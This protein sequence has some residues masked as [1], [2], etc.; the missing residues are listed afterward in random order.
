MS[1]SIT[2]NYSALNVLTEAQLDAAFDSIENKFN[3]TLIAGTEIQSLTIEAGNLAANS[4]TTAKILDSNVTTAKIADGA[5]TGVKRLY[6]VN[7]TAKTT[8]YTATTSDEILLVTATGGAFTITLYAASGNAGRR[9][10][11][12]RTDTTFANAVTIDANLSE[13]IGGAATTT[14][15]TAG[16]TLEIVCD[17]TNWLIV[18]RYI[19]SVCTA[20]TPTGS[21]TGGNVSYAGFWKRVGDVMELDV[22]VSATGAPTGAALTV[23]L[24]TG[25][26]IDTAKLASGGNSS[27]V[28]GQA[29]LKDAGSQ[30][31]V[32]TVQYSSTSAVAILY[33]DDDSSLAVLL[34][35]LTITAPVTIANGDKIC[36]KAKFPITGWNG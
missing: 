10:I 17:G 11:I 1:L 22:T 24:P 31:Y 26:A 33:T 25:V 5:V 13:T 8:N 23:N 28:L 15:H 16:E 19:P 27:D 4:V 20:Y 14:L 35:S 21:W 3:S 12:Q 7:A 32:C 6:S 29:D 34:K 2:R 30:D 9:L 18:R 36:L